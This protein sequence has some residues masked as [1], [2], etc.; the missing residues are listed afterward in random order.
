MNLK[1]TTY[2]VFIIE[3]LRC[4]DYFDGENL[5]EVLGLSKISS[6]HRI[7]LDKADLHKALKEFKNSNYRYLYLSCHADGDGIQINGEDISN[8]EFQRL[9]GSL[10]DRRIFMSVCKGG[11][12]KIAGLMIGESNIL[13]LIGCPLDLDQ[14]QAAIFWPAFFY[15]MRKIDR[16]KTERKYISETLKKL[17]DLFSVSIN[18]YSKITENPSLMRRL[19]I[20]S[21]KK[22]E[23][24]KVLIEGVKHQAIARN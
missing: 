23:N 15:V 7:V 17:V 14:D 8:K 12:R 13:S 9:A 4:G 22:T 18:Y 20:R 19:R 24:T 1:S 6:I 5:D 3:S 2:G 16:K 21:D 10:T 11:N